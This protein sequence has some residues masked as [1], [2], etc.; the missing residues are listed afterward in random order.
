MT[1][2]NLKKHLQEK[3]AII[4]VERALKELKRGDVEIVYISE[5]CRDC[6]TVKRYAKHFGVKVVD[7]PESNKEL[8]VLCKKP[9]A[10]S[11]LCFKK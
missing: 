8:G 10:I 7:I 5:N 2:N 4:G 11:V 9:Y 3:K 6:E 1:V